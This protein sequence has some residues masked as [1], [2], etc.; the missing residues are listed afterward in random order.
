MQAGAQ[1]RSAVVL[2]GVL[3]SGAA[4]A[5]PGDFDTSFGVSGLKTVSYGSELVY[6]DVVQA[7]GRYFAAGITYDGVR[8]RPIVTAFNANGTIDTTFGTNGHKVDTGLSEDVTHVAIHQAFKQT[9]ILPSESYRT[10]I[11]YV[12]TTATKM[13]AY[14]GVVNLNGASQNGWTHSGWGNGTRV[15]L[16][17]PGGGVASFADLEGGGS[18]VPSI[19]TPVSIVGAGKATVGGEADAV[20]IKIAWDTGAV[21]TTFG[22]SGRVYV[23]P[24]VVQRFSGV[25]G[26]CAVGVTRTTSTSAPDALVACF[27]STGL[28][29]AFDGDGIKQFNFGASGLPNTLGRSIMTDG[30]GKI[31]IA[32]NVCSTAN[33]CSLGGAR[34]SSS[35]AFD[36]TFDGDGKSVTTLGSF[37]ASIG[38]NNLIQ[39]GSRVFVAGQ[40]FLDSE[41]STTNSF[42]FAF[43]TSGVGD[44]TFGSGGLRSF[45]NSTGLEGYRGIAVSVDSRIV[46]SGDLD[47]PGT[48]NGGV[49][50]HLP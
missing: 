12:A 48:V 25:S 22:S 18:P 14:Q 9:S 21:I 38:T 5:A 36:T 49:A 45:S 16:S 28:N 19:S 41:E 42:L 50:K 43:N 44:S 37:G 15:T 26:G 20:M 39:I 1:I 29:T 31:W 10:S 8:R 34:L 47:V 46:A 17:F 27:T 6:T 7:A 3:M 35:G 11:Y 30:S 32:A 24:G 33:V 4:I 13:Y 40:L 2:A 23:S